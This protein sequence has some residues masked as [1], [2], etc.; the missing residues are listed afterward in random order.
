MRSRSARVKKLAY[1]TGAIIFANTR[2]P[3]NCVAMQIVQRPLTARAI[4]KINDSNPL[5]NELSITLISCK[6]KYIY[7]TISSRI[8]PTINIPLIKKIHALKYRLTIFHQIEL[9]IKDLLKHLIRDLITSFIA[10]R[11]Y[12]YRLFIHLFNFLI[13]Q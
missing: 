11:Y 7:S 5:R 9:Y 3:R 8:Y 6:T 10:K 13:I 12:I 4:L 2:V 1:R